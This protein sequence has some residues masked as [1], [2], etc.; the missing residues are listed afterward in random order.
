MTARILKIQGHVQG[1]GFR[2]WTYRTARLMKLQGMVANERDGSVMVFVEGPDSVVAD[3]I[4][5]MEKGCPGSL[6]RSVE[7]RTVPVRNLPDFE[8]G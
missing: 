8:I 2:Y 5:E 6:V 1:V 7:V 3:F 4:R